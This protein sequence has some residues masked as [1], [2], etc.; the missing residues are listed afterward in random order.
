MPKE[1]VKSVSHV[2][3]FH[4]DIAGIEVY[5]TPE[6]TARAASKYIIRCIQSVG[7]PVITF[8]TGETMVPVYAHLGESVRAGRVSL[9]SIEARELD[10]YWPCVPTDPHSF[11]GYHRRHVWSLGALVDR[12]Y[13]IDGT[14]ADPEAEARRYGAIVQAHPADLMILGIGPWDDET[15][16]GGH[17]GFNESG[18]PFDRGTH[19]A[20]LHPSTVNRDRVERQQETPDHA[21][22][23]GIADILA[24]KDIMLVAYGANKGLALAHALYDPIS[25]N[26]PASALHSVGKSVRMYID[27]AAA[28][29]LEGYKKQPEPKM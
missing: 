10:E 2:E 19:L 16:S 8:A 3:I 18:T 23:Q 15:Q 14:A 4:P 17:I 26:I 13:E 27:Q 20:R 28:S 12:I 9:T 29:V 11:V 1:A 7:H 21:I 25:V 5:P 6:S 22:T 24:A